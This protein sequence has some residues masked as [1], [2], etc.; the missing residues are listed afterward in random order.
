M[1]DLR[2]VKFP[3]PD[4]RSAK[5]IL[6]QALKA[7]LTNVIVLSQRENGDIY[8]EECDGMTLGEIN[9]IIDSYKFWLMKKADK[10]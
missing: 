8:H 3:A 10:E 1:T 5:E 7:N 9:W 4:P 2:V 6:E